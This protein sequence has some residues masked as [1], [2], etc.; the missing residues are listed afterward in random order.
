M[1][2]G[3]HDKGFV[4]HQRGGGKA[5]VQIAVRPLFERLACGQAPFSGRGKILRGP[6]HGFAW[7]R[8]RRPLRAGHRGAPR[9]AVETRVR[10]IGPEAFQRIGHKRQRLEVDLDAFHRFCRGQL[11]NSGN[12]EDRL[13]GVQRLVRQRLL[14]A[15]EFGQVVCG[16]DRLHARH[17]ERGARIDAADACMR[18]RAEQQLR[19]QH[20]VGAKVLRVARTSGDLRH[21]I[22]RNIVAADKFSGH[23]VS[24]FREYSAPRISAVRILS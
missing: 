11:V 16:E 12:R 5:R 21:V 18:H 9:I 2:R 19:E 4:E 10:A 14:D 22:G 3:L 15:F 8:T 20:A 17:G 7:R 24:A 6:L 1:T 23:Y 13:A